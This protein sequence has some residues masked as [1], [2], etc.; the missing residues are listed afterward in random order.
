MIKDKLIK[1]GAVTMSLALG[2]SPV[3]AMAATTDTTTNNTATSNDLANSD[4]IDESRTGSISTY[5]YDIT[6]AE[7]AGDYEEGM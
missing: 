5:K 2:A 4:I 6:A 7:A 3:V 1:F